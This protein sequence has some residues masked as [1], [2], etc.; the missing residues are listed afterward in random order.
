MLRSRLFVLLLAWGP[1]SAL[2]GDKPLVEVMIL[3][4]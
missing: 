4:T 1:L 2:A 3:G